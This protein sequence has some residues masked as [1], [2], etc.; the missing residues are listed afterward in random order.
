MEPSAEY[1]VGLEGG[2][3]RLRQWTIVKQIAVVIHKEDIGIGQSAGFLCPP[4]ILKQI[5]PTSDSSRKKIDVFFGKEEV[6]SN[7]GPEGVLTNSKLTRTGASRD[8]V[9]FALSRFINPRY[10]K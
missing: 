3:Q 4:E 2:L 9:I 1:T 7:E 8:A 6:L 10:F 5:D